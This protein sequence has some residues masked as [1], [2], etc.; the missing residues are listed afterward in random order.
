M[1]LNRFAKPFLCLMIFF[2]I[3]GVRSGYAADAMKIQERSRFEI[4]ENYQKNYFE[5]STWNNPVQYES[6]PQLAPPYKAGKPQQKYM[7]EALNAVN[8]TRFLVGLP[9][10]ITINEQ[11]NLMAQHASVVDAVND[12]LTHYPSQPQDMPQDFYAMGAKGASSSNMGWGY[13]N[14][15]D[16]II[17]GYMEDGDTGNIDRVGHRR[18]ILNPPM[19]QI[20]FGYADAFT[21]TYVFDRSRAEE[22]DY[23]LI[24]WP[25]K[26]N[27]P[28]EYISSYIP[29]SVNLGR[30]Y[31]IP[32]LDTV[33][34][35]LTNLTTKQ[36]WI[37]NKDSNLNAQVSDTKE[38]F[39]VENSWYG[40]D[41]CIIFRPPV[42]EISYSEDDRFEVSI[43]GIYENGQEKPVKYTV[44]FF[45]I[46]DVPSDW[47]FNEV[48]AA[49]EI[50]LVPEDMQEKYAQNI[51]RA[52]FCRLVMNLVTV[53]TGRPV[54]AVL[55]E[56]G[57]TINETAF[58][59]TSEPTILAAN[60]LGIVEGN[61]KG[62]FI[63][64]GSITRAQ[65]AV[66]LARTAKVLG[67]DVSR[68]GIEFADSKDIADWAKEG[69]AFVSSAEDKTNKAKIMGGTG[70]NKFSPA[71]NYTRQQA[72]ITM[73]RLFHAE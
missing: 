27:M 5:F 38:F 23:E 53:K 16:S 20:G 58:E 14:I 45:S 24:A 33:K 64:H 66:M 72:F 63:P 49:V 3:T 30:N 48:K 35:T 6:E 50:G 31:Q 29:W 11:Y 13:D 7:Q 9:D 8:F 1:K 65:A 40:M 21:A 42:N 60:A 47:A 54:E 68:T 2:L 22:I 44:S 55:E 41:K 4:I 59:D 56:Q 43:E 37:F 73:K 39:N 36:K 25:A 10:D 52:E 18:W 32:T 62:M 19:Q 67:M 15:K 12:V 26:G 57:K 28:V 51:T 71:A 17:A 46:N 70:N 61:G 34:V 69:V